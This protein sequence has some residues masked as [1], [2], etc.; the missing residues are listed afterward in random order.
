LESDR[1]VA[2]NRR[3]Q[4]VQPNLLGQ[5][6]RRVFSVATSIIAGCVAVT[7]VIMG[8]VPRPQI[9]D[10]TFLIHTPRAAPT[11]LGEVVFEHP[12]LTVPSPGTTV[13]VQWTNDLANNCGTIHGIVRDST[14]APKETQMQI[15]V[16]LERYCVPKSLPL[17]NSDGEVE[18]HAVVVI[19]EPSLFEGL[20][21]TI[22]RFAV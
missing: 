3:R 7:F 20:R 21:T 8:W 5:P 2:L 6:R 15:S 1:D 13:E 9:F 19:V 11:L 22:R 4:E 16:R 17:P 18:L 14:V 10:V 12:M